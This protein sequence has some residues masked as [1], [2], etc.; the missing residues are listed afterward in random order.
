VHTLDVALPRRGI[1]LPQSLVTQDK[2]RTDDVG[3]RLVGADF[4]GDFFPLRI[5]NH[6]SLAITVGSAIMQHRLLKLGSIILTWSSG[7][8]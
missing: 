3:G 6:E 4:R 5:E 7:N 8:R 1:V 2:D